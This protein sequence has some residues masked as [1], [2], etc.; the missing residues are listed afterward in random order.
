MCFSLWFVIGL[1]FLTFFVL[2]LQ[3]A[4]L[5]LS[6]HIKNKELHQIKEF[7]PTTIQLLLLLLLLSLL[8]PLRRIFTITYL[9]Q[10]MFLG[11]ILLQLFCICSLCYM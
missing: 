10:T 6:Q 4:L 2:T 8:S 9:Q 1:F 11:Y 7:N 5:V 3:L